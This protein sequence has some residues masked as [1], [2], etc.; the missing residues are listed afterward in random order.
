MVQI[1][2]V[3]NYQKPESAKPVSITEAIN[4]SKDDD[5]PATPAGRVIHD[6]VE[7]SGSASTII[8][9]ARSDEL[10]AELRSKTVD[11]N[12]ASD[13]KKALQD[14][15]RITRLFTETIKAA[16]KF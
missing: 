8:N 12:F 11:D 5:K 14:I 9:L 2:P 1:H 3:F 4:T 7:I 10:G 16:F 15:F 13:L 6:T